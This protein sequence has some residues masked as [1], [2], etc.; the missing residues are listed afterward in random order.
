MYVLCR[1]LSKIIY[2]LDFISLDNIDLLNEWNC[3]EP[4]LFNGEDL[5]LEAI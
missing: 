3:E 2:A 5:S 4:N 1:N